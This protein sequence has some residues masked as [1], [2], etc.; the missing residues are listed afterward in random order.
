M[1]QFNYKPMKKPCLICGKETIIK[2]TRD[3]PFCSRVCQSEARFRGRYYGS[4]AEKKDRSTRPIGT[5]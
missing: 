4:G 3:L 1:A 5:L 2:S